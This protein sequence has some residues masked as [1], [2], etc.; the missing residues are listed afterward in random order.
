MGMVTM[1]WVRKHGAWVALGMALGGLVYAASLSGC[2]GGNGNGVEQPQACLNEY[3]LFLPDGTVARQ[4]S[5]GG[6]GCAPCTDLDACNTASDCASVYCGLNPSCV[7]PTCDLPSICMP[8]H[9]DN[10]VQDGEEVGVDCG[11]PAHCPTCRQGETGELDNDCS[12]QCYQGR[13]MRPEQEPAF[14]Y[15]G[16]AN[17]GDGEMGIDCGGP[18][19]AG[20]P[21]H[22]LCSE[23][24]DCESLNCV[25]VEAG[26]NATKLCFDRTCYN[27]VA[28]GT[29]TDV[30]CGGGCSF[31]Q[32]GDSCRQDLDC[33]TLYCL[34]G[35]CQEVG[36]D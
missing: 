26:D 1:M 21:A 23:D 27:G 8:A 3:T 24:S 32:P 36:R 34:G 13:C 31:C 5:C 35:I 12:S 15:D 4:V 7:N 10:G 28:D 2:G 33:N 11:S 9:C 16:N 20:C 14:C 18:C 17:F 6:P 22:G 25:L 19:V 29:E 30:D